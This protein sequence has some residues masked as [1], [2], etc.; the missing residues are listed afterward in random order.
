GGVSLPG[1]AAGL[2]GGQALSLNGS[3]QHLQL[4]TGTGNYRDITLATWVYWNGGNAWQRVFDFGSEIEKSM[5]LTVKDGSGKLAFQMTTSRGTDG[6]VYLTGSVMPTATWTHVAVT[7]NGDTATLYVNGVPVAATTGPMVAPVFSQPFCYLGRSMWNGDA[8]FNG[9]IDDFRIY[10]HALSGSEVYDLVSPS[11]NRAPTFTAD[12]LRPVGATEDAA[13]NP[14]TG[15][16]AFATDPDGG[17]LTYTK[18][19]GPDWLSVSS[20]GTLSGTPAN[21]DVGNN[22]FVVRVTD[23]AGATD[24]ANLHITV[25]NTNDAPVWLADPLVKPPVTRDQPYLAV[26]LAANAADDDASATLAFSKSTG[27]LWLSVAADGSLS[28]TPGVA[29]VGSNVF[30][31]RVTDAVGAFDE[32]VL[33]ITVLP[34]QMRSHHA[35][36]DNTD[37]SLGNYHGTASGDPVYGTGRLARGMVFDGVDDFVS[38]PAAAADSQ[39]ISIATWVFWKGGAGNQ[40]I[41]DF[42][43]DTSQYLFLSPDSGGLRFAIKN[44]GGEQQVGTTVLATGQWV[45]VTVTLSG[46]TATLYVNGVSVGTNNAMTIHPGDFKPQFNYIG[47]S[48]WPDPLFNGVI[49][50]FRIYNH[51]IS[52]ADIALLLDIPPAVP[53]GLSATPKT[54]RID[55]KWGIAHGAQS[56]TVKRSQTSGGPYTSIASGVTG[57]TFADTTVTNGV[58][59]YYVTSATNSKGTSADSEEASAVPS[60]LLAW[61]KLDETTGTNAADA[62]GNGWNGTLTNGPVWAP[63]LYNGG[64]TIPA[65]NNESVTLPSGIVSGLNDFTISGWVKV[66]TFGTFARI[67]DF[68]TGTNNYM[69]LTPQYTAT[70][71]NAAKFRFAIRTPSVAE[72]QLTS[73]IAVTAGTWTHYAVTLSGSTGRLYINGQLA[74]TNTGMTLKPS[75]LGNTTLN[76]LG[77]SQFGADPTLNGQ[78]DDFRIHSRA[79]TGTEILAAVNPSP[80]VPLG[81]AVGA[82][83]TKLPLAWSPADFASSYTVKRSS[84]SGGPY[85]VVATGVSGTTYTDIGLTNDMTYFYVVSATNT[86]GSSAESAEAYGTPTYLRVHLKFDETTGT[87]ATD[88]SGLGWH[89]ATINGPV[90]EVGKQGNAL[91]FTGASSQHATLPT[92]VIGGLTNATFMTWVKLNGAPTTWQRIFDFGTGNNNYLFL[93]TQYVAGANAN[94]LRFGIRT[95]TVA[96]QLINSTTT[97]PLGTWTHVAVVLSGSTGRIYLNGNLVGENTAMTLNPSSLGTT[98][99]NYL[100]RSQWPDPYFNGSLDDFR[101]YSRA[102]TAGEVGAYANPLEAPGNLVATGGLQQA[103]LEWS[104]VANA[105]HY[106][107]KS[108]TVAG[109]PYTAIASGLSSPVFI[110]SG[111]T[112]GVPRY[113]VVSAGNLTGDSVDSAEAVVVPES[114]PITEQEIANCRL[115]LPASG[116]GG[117]NLSLSVNPSVEGHR[118]QLQGSPDLT[119]GSWQDVGDAWHGNGGA[120]ENV[121]PVSGSDGKQFYRILIIR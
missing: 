40:R 7:F 120:I 95:A 64:L 17:T 88:F 96:E 107:V 41:F 9:R 76:W 87:A 33:N 53:T 61:L 47:K 30:T 42:G 2:G 98:S 105:S 67:F 89:A 74:A 93:T 31:V 45:H 56:Y 26:S 65:T 15:L 8:Y 52:P 106:T 59:Y 24:D 119:P 22:L 50:G 60:D 57:T 32:A 99:L 90:W 39:D 97:T 37:D 43:N 110:H 78:L 19:T 63:G 116:G 1:Y 55:L 100:G 73:S 6:T 114:L 36:E 3:D 10:N 86:Q 92:G 35:F 75:S 18:V 21:G 66:N 49:D 72:Q 4:P 85:E 12:P 77:D 70:A 108:S 118:Y 46:T 44:G 58:R 102:M 28:G 103:E 112:P 20:N 79:L 109:G 113:Y 62:S 13:Y 94:R 5:M 84:V 54:G 117:M 82:G 104:P 71:P 27:P 115:A 16:S 14:G 25:A 111:L 51:A 81:L 80:G 68:G 83:D 23:P 48:Q 29:D 11:S 69:F 101:I 91:A 34:F 121:L 38:L